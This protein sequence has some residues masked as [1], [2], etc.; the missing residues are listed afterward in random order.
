M[1]FANANCK[2]C[3]GDLNL[4]ESTIVISTEVIMN[5]KE[6]NNKKKNLLRKTNIERLKVRNN[7]TA[8]FYINMQFV[9]GLMQVG[10]GNIESEKAQTRFAGKKQQIYE[11]R[12]D[13]AAKMGTY[14]T[15]IAAVGE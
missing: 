7:S 12:I 11:E 5:C 13:K 10:G 8:S 15:G 4:I 3:G 6:Y 14:K 9:L 2:K 1:I